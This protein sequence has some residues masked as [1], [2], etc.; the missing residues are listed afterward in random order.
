MP[1]VGGLYVCAILFLLPDIGPMLGY[2]EQD[3]QTGIAFNLL[4]FMIGTL[5]HEGGHLAAGV[6]MGGRWV[7]LGLGPVLFIRKGQRWAA[8]RAKPPIPGVLVRVVPS[9][10]AD[11]RWQRAATAA[12]GPVASL[13][14]ALACAW[15]A[16]VSE[17][18]VVFWL[19]IKLAA[20]SGFCVIQL[21]P[22]HE[23][24][25]PSDGAIALEMLRCAD[26][27][28]VYYGVLAESSNETS[29]RYRDWPPDVM[30]RFGAS[31]DAYRVLLAYS[32][33]IDQKDWQTASRLIRRLAELWRPEDP[34][35][36]ACELAFHFG[37]YEMNAAEAR[38]WLERIPPAAAP[39]L[40]R[41]GKAAVAFAE[42][43]LDTATL[44]AQKQIEFWDG[45]PP[46]GALET[47]KDTMKDLLD[48]IAL[49]TSAEARV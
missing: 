8:H 11:F 49:R 14:F 38:V 22:H 25:R 31:A 4:G 29:C 18:A 42:G 23:E 47:C 13:L 35:H 43:D 21:I 20:W 27:D 26:L 2:A 32:H 24:G 5:V 28:E 15:V 45:Q 1:I 46:C 30:A 9:R 6:A 48:R 16:L 36:G 34:P 33:A 12:C 7:R 39:E 10:V 40:H 19:F 3:W 41:A 17:S 44:L 37:V